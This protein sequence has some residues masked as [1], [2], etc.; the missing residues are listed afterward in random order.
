[1]RAWNRARRAHRRR[2]AADAVH[3]LRYDGCRPVRG[4]GSR[5]A[6]RTSIAVLRV[7]R[8]P[9]RLAAITGRPAKRSPPT[10]GRSPATARARIDESHCIGCTLLHRCLP[11]RCDPRRPKQMHVFLAAPLQ[12]LRALLAPWPG[13]LHRDA[14]RRP[15]MACRR[16]RGGTV[17]LPRAHRTLAAGERIA[18]R[19]AT[20]PSLDAAGD[21]R[22]N[23]GRGRWNERAPGAPMRCRAHLTMATHSPRRIAVLFAGALLMSAPA[24]GANFS[25][26]LDGRWDYREPEVSEARV[27]RSLA[28]VSFR[29]PA[30]AKSARKSRRNRPRAG[31]Q[32]KFDAPTPPSTRSRPISCASRRA[33]AH[34]WPARARRLFNSSGS[35]ANAVPLFRQAAEVATR[36]VGRA[37]RS[38]R[39]TR[40]TCWASPPRSPSG[41]T[42]TCRAL[43]VAERS[44]RG[45]RRAGVRRCTKTSAG[46]TSTAAKHASALGYWENSLAVREASGDSSARASRDG[47][48]RAGIRALGRLDD[49]ERMQR[50]LAEDNR[51][52]ARRTATSTR[53]WPISGSH[54]ACRGAAPLA[55]KALLRCSARTPGSP[56]RNR[57]PRTAREDRR[58]RGPA[59]PAPSRDERRRPG[60]RSRATRAA[61]PT[62]RPSS[63]TRRR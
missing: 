58:G 63:A 11:G 62:R 43:E 56:Q 6:W 61:N 29:A 27:S 50:D 20:V 28:T 48:W 32:R 10:A 54:G 22:R 4:R 13:R 2:P 42:G 51:A 44:T 33:R 52:R 49:A 55:A 23:R 14:S 21:A 45:A 57:A 17:P 3:A 24:R 37:T 26:Q 16:R 15:R 7:R 47:R 36:A 9:C 40:C 31:L 38:T 1:M 46:R 60:A 8:A 34:P 59:P 19:G 5:H 18:D 53:N 39:S 30:R 25:A 12:R 35:P 41:S